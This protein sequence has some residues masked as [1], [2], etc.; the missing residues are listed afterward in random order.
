VS[1]HYDPVL[2]AWFFDV[3]GQ[4]RAFGDPDRLPS[5]RQ[6]LWLCAHGLLELRDEPAEPLTRLDCALAIDRAKEGEA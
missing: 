5:G 2:D 4:V 1:L 6:L 3:G